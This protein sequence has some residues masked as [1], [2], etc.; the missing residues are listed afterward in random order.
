MKYLTVLA[1]ENCGFCRRASK[2]LRNQRQVVWLDFV[3]AGSE[4]AR[5]RFPELDHDDTLRKITVISDRG[6]VYRGDDA[7]LVCLWALAAWRPM[8]V[9]LSRPGKARFVRAATALADRLRANSLGGENV[10][11]G[12]TCNHAECA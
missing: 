9:S 6:D 1:D 12:S 3:A 2:W 7:W 11:R 5:S 8:A 4:A 10:P